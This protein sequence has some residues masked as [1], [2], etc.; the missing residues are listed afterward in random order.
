MSLQCDLLVQHTLLSP[1]QTSIFSLPSHL[2]FFFFF[3]SPHSQP[4]P[5]II[6]AWHRMNALKIYTLCI[7]KAGST[8]TND[9]FKDLSKV[10]LQVHSELP[11][12]KGGLIHNTSLL[13]LLHYVALQIGFNKKKFFYMI[14]AAPLNM[15]SFQVVQLFVYY[16]Y[17][18][19]SRQQCRAYWQDV[20]VLSKAFFVLLFFQN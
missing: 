4:V 5:Y 7:Y 10:A 13:N 14:D 1:P 16:V 11:V 8:V 3:S 6:V 19:L 15:L 18:V 9:H 12:T 17:C 2:P 20:L